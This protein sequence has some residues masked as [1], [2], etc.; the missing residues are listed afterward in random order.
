MNEDGDS[1]QFRT[2]ARIWITGRLRSVVQWVFIGCEF[3]AFVV[4]VLGLVPGVPSFLSSDVTLRIAIAFASFGVFLVA[5]FNRL[6]DDRIFGPIQMYQL[7]LL[8]RSLG[9]GI[10]RA[11]YGIPDDDDGNIGKSDDSP[12]PKE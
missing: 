5:I 11:I 3:V 2:L 10:G 7:E 9:K 12:K 1:L 4:A 6:D 8:S